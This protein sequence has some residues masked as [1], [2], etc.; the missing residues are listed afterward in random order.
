MYH[1]RV[2]DSV[3]LRPLRS[4]DAPSFFEAIRESIT[5]LCHWLPAGF[6][7]NY[8]Y[9]EAVQWL[10][11]AEAAREAGTDYRFGLFD[12]VT[13]EFLGAVGLNNVNRRYN[14]ANL[15]YWVRDSRHGHG[16]AT[17]GARLMAQVG[18]VELKFTRL[19]ILALPDNK[20]SCR[21]AE[22]AGAT[23]EGIARNRLIYCGCPADAVV[24]SLTPGVTNA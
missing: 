14:F 8:S 4:D 22:K 21:V 24:Y 1:S 6:H 23:R 20:P 19:E 9:D 10:T 13:G 15:G 17:T 5:S 3:R 11:Q 7:A 2:S 16:V 18:L 12:N